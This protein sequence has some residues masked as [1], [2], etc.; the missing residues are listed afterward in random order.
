METTADAVDAGVLQYADSFAL[1]TG[2]FVE[3]GGQ[4]MNVR[5][6]AAD[7][8]AAADSAKVP[9]VSSD[10][11]A[12]C[13]WRISAASSEDHQPIWGEGVVNGGRGLMLI[14]QKY[15]GANTLEV[16]E[17][18]ERRGGRDAPRPSRVG[19]R[20]D[21]LPA[22]DVHRAVDRQPDDAR[23][24]SAS[25]LVILIIV[26]FLLEWRTAFIS[27]IAIPLSL[28]SAIARARRCGTEA[29]T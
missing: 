19:D 26:A 21:D 20:H 5:Q 12:C 24:C 15:R 22:R 3:S 2:G 29:S 18:V 27:L 11:R 28:T 7:H 9:V 23:C 14:V 1:G 6:R 16:T 17:G 13:A 25:L 4:R 10:R 8:R